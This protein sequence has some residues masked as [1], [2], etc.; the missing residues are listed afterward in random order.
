MR[1]EG[2]YG[3]AVLAPADI[4]EIDDGLWR[5]TA[6]HPDWRSGA[7]A[8]SASDWPPE[9]GGVAY[10]AADALLLVDPLVPDGAD[11]LWKW[12]EKRA[13]ERNGTVTVVTT[14]KWHRRSRDEVARRLGA[15]TSR[16]LATLP[17]GVETIPIRNAGE[18]MVWLPDARTLIPGDRLIGGDRRGELR[19]CPESWL[20]YLESGITLP[21]LAEALRPLLELPVE[22]VLVSHGKPIL[23]DGRAALAA[24]LG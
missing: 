1:R 2:Q 4:T 10:L 15:T 7:E 23:R 6:R 13:A 22:R 9:V 16:A 20:S 24:A 14:L 17:A 8:G 3:S 21:E 11:A 19:M 12:L 5:W 18:T